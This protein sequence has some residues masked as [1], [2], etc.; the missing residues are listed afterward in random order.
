MSEEG[1]EAPEPEPV[2]PPVG[3]NFFISNV[4]TFVG[5]SLVEEL[6]NDHLVQ[7]PVSV[8]KFVGTETDLENAPVP[9]GVAKIVKTDKTRS[10][11]KSIMQSDVVIYDL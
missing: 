7:E 6:R 11:R 3:K 10:F 1:S 5:Q 4:N 2:P 8:H 9:S